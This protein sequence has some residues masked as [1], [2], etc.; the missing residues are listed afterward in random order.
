MEKKAIEQF[1]ET[2]I[3]LKAEYRQN[4]RDLSTN[5]IADFSGDM[6]AGMHEWMSTIKIYVKRYLIGHP[7][8][9]DINLVL[10]HNKNK[11]KDYDKMMGLLRALAQDIASSENDGVSEDHRKPLRETFEVR[12]ISNRLPQNS[13]Y[14]LKEIVE[15]E[16]PTK[17]ICERFEK[18]SLQEDEILRSI[19]RELED[20][21]YIKIPLWA[22]NV[23]QYIQIN[24]S[25]RTYYEKEKEYTLMVEANRELKNYDVFISHANSDKSDYVNQLVLAIKKLGIN[26][27]YDSDVLSWGDN[28]K[29]TILS[30]TEKSEFAIIV[31]SERF[32][33]R[34]WTERELSEFL[35]RQNIMNQ[36][37]VL[38]LLHNITFEQLKMEYPALQYIQSIRSDE[39]SLEEI[40]IFLAK[41]LIK[42]Y[43]GQK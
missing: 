34:E 28:W 5:R 36:K 7:L 8:Y 33:G 9:D 37:I 14:L 42:R 24:N 15:S 27:F 32:F 40:A 16:N 30:G 21:E 19:L 17:M 11:I 6:P 10:F 39:Y 23:P 20:K 35:Q 22:D 4:I 38:P 13:R 3:K 25:A 29:D 18:C 31:I 2:G 41:E 43:K 12:T 26:I 1:I